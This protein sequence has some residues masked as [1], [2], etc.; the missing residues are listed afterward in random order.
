MAYHC[1]VD[2]ETLGTRP[3]ASILS[4]GAVCFDPEK[5]LLHKDEFYM[6]LSF[7]SNINAGLTFD[8]DTLMWWMKQSDSARDQAFGGSE[9]LALSLR[10]F[11]GYYANT[12]GQF[13]PIWSHGASFDVVLLEHAY[14]KLGIDIPWRYTN[15]RDTRT[16]YALAGVNPKD[17]FGF[18]AAAH[19][20]VDDARAQALAVIDAYR[21]VGKGVAYQAP[22]PVPEVSVIS[23]T[24]QPMG[25]EVF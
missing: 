5:G 23:E 7:R 8:I 17:F 18:G 2:L 19:I 9:E 11:A 25:A 12:A 3:S 20:A 6:R 24:S 21:R 15:I 14:R 1:M 10:K 4:I 22:P 16:I 13:A